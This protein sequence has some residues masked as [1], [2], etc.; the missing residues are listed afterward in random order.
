MARVTPG[1]GGGVD[2][3]KPPAA[4]TSAVCVSFY[5]SAIIMNIIMG[6]PF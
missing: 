5:S 6:F 2:I 4:L 1:G 3:E